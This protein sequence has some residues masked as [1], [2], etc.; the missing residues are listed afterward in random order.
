MSSSS[1]PRRLSA[2]V[3]SGAGRGKQLGVPTINFDTKVA[4]GLRE[5]IY[6]CKVVFPSCYYWGVLHFGPRPTFGE[7]NKSLEVYLFNFDNVQIPRQLD[8]EVY[9]YIRK[10]VKFA[11]P[12]SMIKKIGKD[13]ILA[14]RR[15][16]LVQ[17]RV[18][19][20]QNN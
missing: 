6:V 18:R 9:S 13:I 19:R 17:N 20:G 15:I 3:I 16:K 4:E 8:I 12:D 11:N 14:K 7:E 1:S 2:K 10:I 5:G